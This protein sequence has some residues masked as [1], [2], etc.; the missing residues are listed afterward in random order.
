MDKD[1]KINIVIAIG[2]IIKYYCAGWRCKYF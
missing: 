1:N 2:F